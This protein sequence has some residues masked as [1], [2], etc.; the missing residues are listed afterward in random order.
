[1]YEFPPWER[2]EG[3]PAWT[4]RLSYT[5]G[6][7][8]GAATI[9]VGIAALNIL[10]YVNFRASPVP[11]AL[12]PLSIWI[13][14]GPELVL[15]AVFP[16][17]IPAIANL[18]ISP[19]GLRFEFPF[20]MMSSEGVFASWNQVGRIGSNWVEVRGVRGPGFFWERYR[21]SAAQA[22]RLRT[23]ID[24]RPLSPGGA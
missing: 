1:M 19:I 24:G 11:S 14:L 3:D 10:G 20:P 13:I 6:A 5:F 16:R 18:G 4:R 8:A 21:L 23:F 17:W 22:G 7:L 15:L 12:G 2:A 9:L